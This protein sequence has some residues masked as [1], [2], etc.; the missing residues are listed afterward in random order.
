MLAESGPSPGPFGFL[1]AFLDAQ[2]GAAVQLMCKWAIVFSMFTM[3][4][5]CMRNFF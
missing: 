3:F 5:L 4:S 2:S 1:K